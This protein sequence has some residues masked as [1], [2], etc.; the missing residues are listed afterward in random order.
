[1]DTIVYS[2]QHQK[3]NPEDK[4]NYK[5]IQIRSKDIKSIRI[6]FLKLFLSCKTKK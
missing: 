2:L 5:I 6:D 1:M 3:N 4:M